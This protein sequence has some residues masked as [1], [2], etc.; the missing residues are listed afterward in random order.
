MY[1]CVSEDGKLE[2][3]TLLNVEILNPFT[4]LRTSCR[5]SPLPPT[6]GTRPCVVR[7]PL[8]TGSS[9]SSRD[10]PVPTPRPVVGTETTADVCV[11]RVLSPFIRYAFCPERLRIGCS[12]HGPST[13]RVSW[14]LRECRVWP[15]PG[16]RPVG[17]VFDSCA[18]DVVRGLVY[19]CV[20]SM[21]VS[22]VSVCVR[23]WP[24][25]RDVWETRGVRAAVET[26]VSKGTQSLGGPQGT[27]P[28]PSRALRRRPGVRSPEHPS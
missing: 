9:P 24:T 7:P 4:S 16:S 19:V 21:C 15:D 28:G 20:S 22:L 13:T 1:V 2:G 23:P 18:S 11:D 10:T 25:H 17:V 3:K 26:T 8:V 27:G 12:L 14:E 6:T 5:T